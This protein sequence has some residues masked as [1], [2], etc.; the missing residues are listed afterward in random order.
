M[1]RTHKMIF[2]LRALILALMLVLTGVLPA[3]AEVAQADSYVVTTIGGV[4]LRQTAYSTAEVLYSLPEGTVLPVLELENGWYYVYYRADYGFVAADYVRPALESEIEKYLSQAG[5]EPVPFAGDDLMEEEQ[6]TAV[7]DEPGDGYLNAEEYLL[8]GDP[9]SEEE[10]VQEEAFFPEE[11]PVQAE[12]PVLPEETAQAG[13]TVQ[14]EET[15]AAGQ[16][17]LSAQDVDFEETTDPVIA[18]VNTPQGGTLTLRQ[19][20]STRARAITYLN[21]GAQVYVLDADPTWAMVMF[22]D[23]T[24]YVLADYLTIGEAE[25]EAAEIPETETEVP[26]AQEAQEE[27]QT[28]PEEEPVPAAQTEETAF[29]VTAQTGG[30]ALELRATANAEGVTIARIPDESLLVVFGQDSYFYATIYGGMTGYIS[31][32][33]VEIDSSLT[34][35]VPYVYVLSNTVNVRREPERDAD[36]SVRVSLGDVLEMWGSPYVNDGYTWYPVIASGQEGYLR[37]DTCMMLSRSQLN[38]YQTNGIAPNPADYEESA[39]LMCVSRNVNVRAAAATTA[40]SLGKLG[41][42]DVLQ[43]TDRISVSGDTWYRVVYHDDGAF[44]M[45][46]YVRVLTNEEYA[47]WQSSSLLPEERQA[48]PTAE[49]SAAAQAAAELAASSGVASTLKDRVLIRKSPSVLAASVTRIE[50]SETVVDLLGEV[51]KDQDGDDVLWYLVEYGAYSGWIR[52]DM[53]YIYSEEEYSLIAGGEPQPEEITPKAPEIVVPDGDETPLIDMAFTNQE[54]VY[55]RRAPNVQSPSVAIIASEHTYLTVLSDAKLDESGASYVWYEVQY[56]NVTGYVRGD[57]ITLMTEGMWQATFGSEYTEQTTA[58]AP[59]E[60]FL[61]YA[62]PEE[63]QP[64]AQSGDQQPEAAA[65]PVQSN[66]ADA[67]DTAYTLQDNVIVRKAPSMTSASVTR[68][69]QMRTFVQLMGGPFQDQDGQS[70]TWYEIEYAMLSGY[71]RSDMLHIVTNEEW[72]EMVSPAAEEPL[73]EEPVM[74]GEPLAPYA[75]VEADKGDYVTYTTLRLGSVGEAVTRLQQ[76]LFEQGYLSEDDVT[77]EYTTATVQAVTTFQQ[78]N[79]LT[80]DGIAGQMTQ[81]SLFGTKSYDGKLYPVEKSNWYT[82]SIQHVW[83]RGTIAV[84]TDVYTGLAFR[85]RRLGGG[86]HADVEPLTSADTA[87]MCRIYGVST[88]EE[89]LSNKHWQRRPLWVTVGGRTYAASMYGVPHN[90]PDGDSIPDNDFSGQFCVHFVNSRVHRTGE[91]DAYHQ[92]AIQYAYSHAPSK[93]K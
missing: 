6:E 77:G 86:Y 55:L 63:I 67:T 82:G 64:E 69:S 66:S 34:A 30:A 4:S 58:L 26:E 5:E 52:G 80:A 12:A 87:V 79:K 72:E 13:E 9:V 1:L 29:C 70:Y 3:G 18:F 31:M 81:S 23:V 21:N 10:P 75:S 39:Y 44:V 8:I 16:T 33:Q 28:N 74:P 73:P 61:P 85:A 35:K 25:S 50:K 90:Y 40:R 51:Q 48:Q 19:D 57:L 11:E 41:E 49:P 43:W 89:I 71:V 32:D 36:V 56:N 15:V 93:K 46:D 78:D 60:E 2:R 65:Q 59:E 76:A 88:S 84:I 54:R 47:L 24:G 68:I 42:G 38:N 45:G 53:L 91:I 20:K 22:E 27:A 17:V 37:G 83:T 62:E 14:M 92:Q 7:I